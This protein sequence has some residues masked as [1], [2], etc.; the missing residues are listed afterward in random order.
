MGATAVAEH[1][2]NVEMFA[3]GASEVAYYFIVD[4]SDMKTAIQAV[5]TKFFGAE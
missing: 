1:G 5:H 2:I 3:A 4:Q